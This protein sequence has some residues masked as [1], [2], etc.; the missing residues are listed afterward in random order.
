MSVASCHSWSGRDNN[1]IIDN[2]EF[3]I[4]FEDAIRDT[5]EFIH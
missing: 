4:F 5:H 3:W 1:I 2:H